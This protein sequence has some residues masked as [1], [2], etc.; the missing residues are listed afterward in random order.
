MLLTGFGFF[1]ATRRTIRYCWLP[2]FVGKKALIW[3]V[4]SVLCL[5]ALYAAVQPSGKAAATEMVHSHSGARQEKDGEGAYAD[6][7]RPQTKDVQLP[8]VEGS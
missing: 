4:D 2:F 7:A 1:K 8:W 6:R 3:N 5:D